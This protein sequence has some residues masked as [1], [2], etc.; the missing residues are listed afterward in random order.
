[1]VSDPDGKPWRDL[2]QGG[3]PSPFVCKSATMD[4]PIGGILWRIGIPLLS[5]SIDILAW[6][7][8]RQ[9][10]E[11]GE[12]VAEAP[13]GGSSG[14]AGSSAAA[15]PGGT[16]ALRRLDHYLPLSS[17][18]SP[19]CSSSGGYRLNA[20]PFHRAAATPR[21]RRA[22]ILCRTAIHHAAHPRPVCGQKT[23]DRDGGAPVA[24]GTLSVAASRPD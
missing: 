13:V 23:Y 10:L 1:M 16:V 9:I 3:A 24:A 2:H 8:E 19:R 18:R 6:P 22:R 4:A 5:S 15:C 12:A 14:D 17:R 20:G 11:V 7:L 21:S